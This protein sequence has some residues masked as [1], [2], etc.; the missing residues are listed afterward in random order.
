MSNI[1]IVFSNPTEGAEKDYND[2][3]TNEHLDEILAYPGWKSATR[4]RLADSGQPEG[5]PASQHRYLTIYELDGDPG[6]AVNALQDAL[7]G[8]DVVLPSVID[9]ASIQA[10][11]WT[12]V[13][14]RTA[15]GREAAAK[16]K[17]L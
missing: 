6:D 11:S 16:T 10:W 7:K 17:A 8:G 1:F 15:T 14:T 9:V 5:Y 3:Y 12:S 2:W 13:V 4:Y